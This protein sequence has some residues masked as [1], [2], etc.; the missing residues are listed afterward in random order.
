VQREAYARGAWDA[1]DPAALVRLLVRDAPALEGLASSL[2]WISHPGLWLTH[3]L[4]RNS[5]QGSRR[6]ITAHYDLGNDFFEAF[7]DPSM[8]YSCGIFGQAGTSLEEASLA[9]HDRVLDKL[10]LEP[11]SRLLEIGTGWGG[12][13]LRA[14]ERTDAHVTTNTVSRAQ[15]ELAARRLAEAGLDARVE[16][17]LDDYRDLSGHYD[18][19]VSIEMVEAVGR[20]HLPDYFAALSRHLED[21]S[22]AVLQVIT[23]PDQRF[24]QAARSM[25][26]I[27]RHIF[28][29]GC[30]PSVH[31][32]LDAARLA[33][34]LRLVHLEDLTPHYAETLRRWR[35]SLRASWEQLRAR[36]Y[37]EELLRTFEFYF[38]YCEGGFEE[39]SIGL[40]QLVFDRP[41]SRLPAPTPAPATGP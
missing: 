30:L 35:G 20:E 27:K 19:I 39:R 34:D 21:T 1:D 28:P 37:G 26:F 13:A 17:R 5:R 40:A 10:A 33:S 36:G 41:G 7:L 32:L 25:D 23:I 2:A 16:L 22:R 6:N 8:T 9:K 29:G 24:D 31:A 11:G 12:F 18:R 14:A 3:L 38:A 4:R 15:Y